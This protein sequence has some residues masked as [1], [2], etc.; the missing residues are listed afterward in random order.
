MDKSK[1]IFQGDSH[2]D[3]KRLEKIPAPPPWR[4]FKDK[5]NR[6][7]RGETYRASE[8]E[9][10]L[11]NTAMYVRRPLLI[12]G[13][14]GAGKSSLAYAVAY[15][16][17]LG[18][19]LI[20]PITSK[21]NLQQGQYAYDAIGRLQ[22]ASR[23][24]EAQGNTVKVDEAE[25]I[26]RFIRL[27]PIGTAFLKS[28]SERPCVVLIDEIDKSDID[29]PNDLLH[30][31]EEGEFEI[32]ELARLPH[33]ILQRETV[34][35]FAHGSQDKLQVPRN[36]VVRC[37]AFPLIIMTSNGEREFPPAFLRR[38]LR[39]QLDVPNAEKIAEIVDA[40]LHV[41]SS[42]LEIKNL[43]DDFL[44]IRDAEHKQVAIDQLLNAVHLLLQGVSLSDD[45]T[46][47]EAIFKALVE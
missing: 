46:L 45:S 32:P 34:P 5:R 43:I 2:Q 18:D 37:Q 14:P 26:G 19:V 42:N 20:W 1:R 23:P 8:K 38:C 22:E 35:V 21:S 39:L 16:L 24:K 40:H 44:T 41:T 28:R 29:L 6:R 33:D 12:T 36:G 27:G 47:R 11:V 7:E 4:E 15:E 31:F 9:I 3:A 10:D 30:L 13:H 17:A 25:D